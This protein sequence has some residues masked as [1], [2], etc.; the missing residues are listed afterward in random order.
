MG[1]LPDADG[2]F[3]ALREV[4]EILG[5]GDF[6]AAIGSGIAGWFGVNRILRS[7]T[8]CHV[9]PTAWADRGAQRNLRDFR[10]NLRHT[11]PQRSF[12]PPPCDRGGW[13]FL[14]ALLFEDFLIKLKIE[15]LFEVFT[16]IY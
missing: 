1:L 4:A 5:L 3:V 12:R 7:R 2:V 11:F 10:S 15:F 6:Q 14:R 9:A 13:C 8:L 16:T